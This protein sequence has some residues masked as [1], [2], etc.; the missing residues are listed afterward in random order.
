MSTD[1]FSYKRGA[2][3]PVRIVTLA[4]NGLSD[5][6]SL[7][8]GSILFVYRTIGVDE[9]KT[10]TATIFDSPT[11]K[12]R[13]DFGA[14]DSATLGKYQWHIEAQVGG[15]TMCFPEKGFYSFSITDQIEVV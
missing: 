7:D 5:L 2:R 9:R 10:I 3:L 12:I 6:S 11:M 8:V 13:V 1:A 15:L 14:I 4:G